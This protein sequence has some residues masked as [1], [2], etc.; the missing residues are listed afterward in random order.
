MSIRPGQKLPESAESL[1]G[2]AKSAVLLLL[3][4]PDSAGAILRELPTEAV[5]EVTRALA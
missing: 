5:E 1:D 2:V 3:L 4:D